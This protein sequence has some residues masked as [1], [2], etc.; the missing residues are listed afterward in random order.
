MSDR[1]T[2]DEQPTTEVPVVTAEPATRRRPRLLPRRVP[3]RI[4]RARTS[5]LVLALLFVAAFFSWDPT[6]MSTSLSDPA[7]AS[8][9][10]PAVPDEPTQAPATTTSEPVPTTTPQGT[11]PSTTAPTT[12]S[13][14]TTTAP[15][16]TAPDDETAPTTTPAPTTTA[17]APTT[18]SAPTTQAPATSA[19][20]TG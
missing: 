5:T 16:T 1:P 7:P 15:S 19:A 18:S 10:Q 13:R 4:G 9:T 17:P 6:L 20:P 2:P 12:T 3:A 11:T 8:T 14:P